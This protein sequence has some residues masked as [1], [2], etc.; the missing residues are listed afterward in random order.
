MGVPTCHRVA[1]HCMDDR[2]IYDTRERTCVTMTVKGKIVLRRMNLDDDVFKRIRRR[3]RASLTKV[4][5]LGRSQRD[6]CQITS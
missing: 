6:A 4:S 3:H 1:L 2:I 5:T